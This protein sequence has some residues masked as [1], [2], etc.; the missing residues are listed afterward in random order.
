MIVSMR[1]I[2]IKNKTASDLLDRITGS[3]GQGETEAIISALELYDRQLRGQSEVE[4][5]IDWIR[6]NVHPAVKPEFLGKAPSK[7][8]IEEELELF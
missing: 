3:T 2:N 7:A 8:E 6:N 5:Q 1:Q 4:A